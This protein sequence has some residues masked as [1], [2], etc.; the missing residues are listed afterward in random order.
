MAIVG[1]EKK[2]NFEWDVL[3]IELGEDSRW[4]IIIR[5]G[6]TKRYPSRYTDANKFNQIQFNHNG[7][8]ITCQTRFQFV[9][10]LL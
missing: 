4:I 1:R 6:T 7:I 9:K 5:Y 10:M 2:P 8:L 3:S